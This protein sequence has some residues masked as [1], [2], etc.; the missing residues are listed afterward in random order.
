MRIKLASKHEVYR[1][2]PGYLEQVSKLSYE[3]GNVEC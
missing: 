1:T 3:R 2:V